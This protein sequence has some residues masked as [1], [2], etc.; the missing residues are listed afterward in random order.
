VIVDTP[1]QQDQDADN[2]A[3]II[4]FALGQVPQDMQMILGTVS[5]HGVDYDGYVIKTENK[6]RLLSKDAYEEVSGV[7]KPYYAKLVQQQQTI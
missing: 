2:A 4:K 3:R 7:L 5:L 6:Y 1:V